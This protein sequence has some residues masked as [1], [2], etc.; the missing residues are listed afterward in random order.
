MGRA[1]HHRVAVLVD[2]IDITATFQHE[3]H[4]FYDFGFGSGLLER[5]IRADSSR[6]QQRRRAVFVR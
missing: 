1:M 5:R 4:G 2:R 3:L 6:R